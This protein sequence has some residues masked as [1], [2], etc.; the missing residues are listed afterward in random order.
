MREYM[1]RSILAPLLFGAGAFMLVF[2]SAITWGMR[3]IALLSAALSPT[4]AS[5]DE[6]ACLDDEKA[7]SRGRVYFVSCGDF[8]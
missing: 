8:F 6:V 1:R 2:L 5:A 7:S 4:L 3:P